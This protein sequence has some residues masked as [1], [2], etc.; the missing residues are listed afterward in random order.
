MDS[1]V[2]IFTEYLCNLLY[3]N[4][5]PQRTTTVKVLCAGVDYPDTTSSPKAGMST[6]ATFILP[7]C[8]LKSLF[9]TTD[10]GENLFKKLLLPKN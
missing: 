3:C 6:R 7:V 5:D 8:L 4:V 2:Q 9:S 1:K 10:L